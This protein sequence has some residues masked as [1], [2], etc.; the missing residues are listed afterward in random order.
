MKIE[1]PQLTD[2]NA[3]DTIALQ[4]HELHV[5]WRPDIFEHT[6]SIISKEELSE[7][8]KEHNIFVVKIDNIVVGYVLLSR[9]ESKKNGYRYRKQL[10]IDAMG[11][12]DTYRNQGIGFKL[13]EFVK[14]YAKQNN[15]TIIRLTVNEENENARHLYEKVGFKVKNIAYTLN[16]QDDKTY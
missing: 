9:R 5:K 12:L 16:V 15:F 7:L 3:I 4:V 10:D 8:I 14:D 6:D 13:L 1:L 2:L 11:V